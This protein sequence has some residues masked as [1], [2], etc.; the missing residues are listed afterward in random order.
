MTGH[1]FSAVPGQKQVCVFA[2]IVLAVGTGP[3][4]A[5]VRFTVCHACVKEPFRRRNS[6]HIKL[7]SEQR[8]F[9]KHG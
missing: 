9:E 8:S 2:Q 1:N 5:D 6:R 4:S 7:V 3:H